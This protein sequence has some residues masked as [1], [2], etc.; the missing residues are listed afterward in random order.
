V[1]VTDKTR[2]DLQGG[3]LIEYEGK[4]KLVE[5]SQVRAWARAPR[6]PAPPA[7]PALP[8]QVP[9]EHEGDFKSLKTFNC[10]NTNN[11]WVSG[12]RGGGRGRLL[13][14]CRCV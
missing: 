6:A 8:V 11:L 1:Q 12:A 3:T 2:S 7:R 9:R 14:L 10:F 5:L 4:A 13:L